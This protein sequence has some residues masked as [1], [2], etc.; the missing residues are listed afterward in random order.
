LTNLGAGCRISTAGLGSTGFDYLAGVG[1]SMTERGNVSPSEGHG[2]DI[3]TVPS[4]SPI[5]TH[6]TP[7]K[8]T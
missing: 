7:N 3:L 4:N 1:G 5:N 6:Q 8:K 2:H